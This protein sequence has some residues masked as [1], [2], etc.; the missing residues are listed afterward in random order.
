M[1][2]GQIVF[3]YEEREREIAERRLSFVVDTQAAVA[4][5]ASKEGGKA[6]QDH[7]KALQKFIGQD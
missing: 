1:T 7:A 2:P 6:A 3:I 5:I 4:A